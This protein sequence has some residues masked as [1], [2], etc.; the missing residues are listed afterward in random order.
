MDIRKIIKEQIENLFN[1]NF[2]TESEIVGGQIISHLHDLPAVRAEVNWNHPRT[3]YQTPS[4]GNANAELSVFDKAQMAEYISEF[5]RKFGEKPYFKIDGRKI[6]ISNPNFITWRTE[7]QN[8]VQDTLGQ[9][10][11]RD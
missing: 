6:S 5:E 10:G 3:F 11:D 9:W 1:E 4:L 2:A 7:G 8:N